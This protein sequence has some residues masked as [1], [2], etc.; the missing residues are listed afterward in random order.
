MCKVFK[1][2]FLMCLFGSLSGCF[3]GKS[4]DLIIHNAHIH[5]LNDKEDVFEGGD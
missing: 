1:F 3:K 2:I 4:V 5:T